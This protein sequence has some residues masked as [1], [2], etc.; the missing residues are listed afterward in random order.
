MWSSSDPVELKRDRMT[1]R[2]QLRRE[3][4]DDS[5]VSDGDLSLM[6]FMGERTLRNERYEHEAGRRMA[7]N[8][9]NMKMPQHMM[10]NGQLAQEA[11]RGNSWAVAIASVILSDTRRKD[12]ESCAWNL[13]L[14]FPTCT[15]MMSANV[16][17]VRYSGGG[18][19]CNTLI[20]ISC[21]HWNGEKY[22]YG[23]YV[24]QAVELFGME[25]MLPRV[26]DSGLS[27]FAAFAECSKP[28]NS[29]T[30]CVLPF[31]HAGSCQLVP[32]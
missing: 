29:R 9:M 31:W 16:G 24:Q 27:R 13:L 6:L 1:L 14:R 32:R 15:S 28:T 22:P 5:T 23:E 12:V 4:I 20:E 30:R 7:L 21:A 26:T 3:G 25:R 18:K 2:L 11:L 19:H 8:A 10:R 17:A